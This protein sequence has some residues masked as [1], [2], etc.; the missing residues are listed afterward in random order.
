MPQARARPPRTQGA[1]PRSAEEFRRNDIG[2]GVVG[3]AEPKAQRTD[4]VEMRLGGEWKM[5]HFRSVPDTLHELFDTSSLIEP[6][7]RCPTA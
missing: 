5:S 6:R 4:D 2:A 7:V 1:R 3:C